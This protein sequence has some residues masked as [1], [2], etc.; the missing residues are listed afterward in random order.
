MA[1]ESV[2]AESPAAA[3]EAAGLPRARV[4]IRARPLIIGLIVL[5]VLAVAARFG[6]NYWLD[7]FYD[8][9][10]IMRSQVASLAPATL[11]S[12]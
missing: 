4:R 7:S 1:S 5:T 2:S 11:L 12:L 3:P 9:I 6:Y 8:R 10:C